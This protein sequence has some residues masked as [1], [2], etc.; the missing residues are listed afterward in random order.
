MKD[1]FTIQFW[2][3]RG[4]HP[5]PGPHSVYYGGNTAC[6][7]VQVGG[8]TVILDA[9]T[10]I[11]ACGRELLNRQ[12]LSNPA[13]RESA[14]AILLF[15]HLHHD[16]TQGFPFFG[17]AYNP[18]VQL[19]LFGPGTAELAIDRLLD[20]NQ[21]P[22]AFPVSLRD[23]SA[24][25][26]FYS[27]KGGEMIG[28]ESGLPKT[29]RRGI[30]PDELTIRCMRSY[31][32]PGQVLIYRLDWNGRS[33]VYATDTEGYVGGDRRL[34]NFAKDADILIHDAQYTAE[35]YAARQGFG[36]STPQMAAS[37]ARDAGVKSLALFHH[38]PMYDDESVHD[39]EE[40]AQQIFGSSFAAR[41]GLKIEIPAAPAKPAHAS[42]VTLGS[43]NLLAKR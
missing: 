28:F 27:L 4:S 12:L 38:D 26:V 41:E 31:A 23:M 1:D 13:A 25:L 11:I 9:G 10:G 33:L 22:P 3:V 36:H 16:H 6:V 39:L 32:H 17:P 14:Q 18:A 7:E 2:G 21:S 34:A 43:L 37:L 35:D 29:I 8:Y 5:S 30:N 24:A 19:H 40:Q 42:A 15:S 20:R